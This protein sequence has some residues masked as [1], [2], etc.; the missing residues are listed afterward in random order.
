MTAV[1]TILK[2]MAAY[3]PDRFPA[4]SGGDLCGCFRSGFDPGTGQ[5]WVEANIEVMA[6]GSSACADGESGIVRI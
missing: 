3:F 2:A 6:Q 1:E 5:M 4:Q